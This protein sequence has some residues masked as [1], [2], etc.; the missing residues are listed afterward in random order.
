M[1][2]A[3]DYSKDPKKERYSYIDYLQW[4]GRWEL[5]DGEAVD[6]SPAPGTQ[7]QEISMI[8]SLILGNFL[9]SKCCKLYAAPFDVRFGEVQT[10]SYHSPSDADEDIYTVVQ[11]DLVVYCDESKLD[12]K[13]GRGAPDLVIE[14][15]SEST[16]FRDETE[17][18]K[19]YEKHRVPEYWIINPV[20]RF[21]L[22][23]IYKDNSY[24]KPEYLLESEVLRSR[25][26]EGFSLNLVDVWVEDFPDSVR[27]EPPRR[28]QS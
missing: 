9:K 10:K 24:G 11:P 20:A 4:E 16:A 6:M 22:Q 1:N 7:H 17:K 28:E 23:Y 26:L 12:K 3:Y 18:L 25:V 13:G 8:L 27:E 2:L 21:V 19:L 5:L 15:L 14:I